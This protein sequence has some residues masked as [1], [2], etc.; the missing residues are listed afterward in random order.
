MYG[1]KRKKKN[2]HASKTHWVYP[3][4]NLYRPSGRRFSV[5]L[6]PSFAV[7]GCRV[8]RATVPPDR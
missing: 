2:Q 6:M 3:T 4:N 5:K 1:G 8:V 7:Q